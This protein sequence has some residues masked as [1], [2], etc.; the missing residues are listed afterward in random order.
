VPDHCRCDRDQYGKTAVQVWPCIQSWYCICKTLQVAYASCKLHNATLL[1]L[2]WC[3]G[4]VSNLPVGSCI[5]AILNSRSSWHDGQGSNVIVSHV[6]QSWGHK[7]SNWAIIIVSHVSQTS[8]CA[9]SRKLFKFEHVSYAGS[10]YA[11]LLAVM[12]PV[13]WVSHLVLTIT[14]VASSVPYR[15]ANR[16]QQPFYHTVLDCPLLWSVLSS[17]SPLSEYCPILAVRYGP[18]K[19][20]S[21]DFFIQVTRLAWQT[22]GPIGTQKPSSCDCHRDI[23]RLET[24]NKW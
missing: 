9:R 2:L 18:C 11:T 12:L 21:C 17:R 3:H 8:S 5:V 7:L 19:L 22:K 1:K 10:T 13:S 6:S 14:V 4:Y 16:G 20:W 15:G 24:W 23:L